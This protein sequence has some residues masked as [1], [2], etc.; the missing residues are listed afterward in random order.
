MLPNGAAALWARA[1]LRRRWRSLVVLG[2]LVGMTSALAMAALAGARRTSTA[3]GRLR[4]ATRAADAVVFPSQVNATHPDWRPLAAR[5]EVAR[6]AVWDLMFGNVNDSFGGLLFASDDGVFG[7]SVDRPVVVRG[8]MYDPAAPD[9]V[10]VDE[11]AARESP[12]GSTFRFQGY[13]LGTDD[14]SGLPPHGP[15]MTLRVVGVVR[16]VP[17]FLFVSDGQVLVSPGVVARYRSQMNLLENAD[18]VLRHG[19]ADIAALKRD[20]NALVAPGAPVLDL[21]AVSRRVDTTLAVER[22]ALVL[23]AAA[24]AL[25]GGILVAQ[26]LSRSASVVGD[27]VDALRAMGM[28]RADVGLASCLPHLATAAVAAVVALGGAVLASRWFPVGLGRR[29]DPNLGFHLDWTVIGPGVVATLGLV[30]GATLLMG[31]RADRRSAGRLVAPSQIAAWIRRTTPLTIGLGSAMAFERGRGKAAV[32]VRPALTAAAVGVLGIVATVAIDGGINDALAHPER[33]GVSWDADVTAN[34][35]DL[36]PAGTSPAVADRV[37][38]AAGPGASTA[39]VARGVTDVS[40]VGVPMFTVRPPRRSGAAPVAL[41]LKTGRAP[42]A[43]GEAAIGPATAADLHVGIGSTVKVGGAGVPVRIVGEALFPDDVHAEFDEGLWVTPATFDA[44]W[45]PAPDLYQGSVQSVIAVRLPPGQTAAGVSRLAKGLGSD[46]ADVSPRPSPVE[47]VNLRN[48]RVLPE[49][50]AGF[51]ALMAVAALGHVLLTSAR[52]RRRDFAILAA[53]GLGRGAVRRVLNAQGTA[54]GAVGLIVGVPL[55]L[56][57]G[58]VGWRLVTDRVPLL[59]VAPLPLR[60]TLVLLA[61]TVVMVNALAVWPGWLLTR[62][63]M[64]AEELRAE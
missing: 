1:D 25:A 8:R 32:A 41:A 7:G 15:R 33:A 47:L 22:T 19:R 51:L 52:R 44:V 46:V 63:H 35:A 43:T 57:L 64:P 24:V 14:R 50:L 42:R 12:L 11:N 45:P 60:E 18:V 16:T 13:E 31:V 3:L 53:M 55:G 39:E 27:D 20:M 61:A 9:E 28:T 26:A 38:V 49:L 58:R 30:T 56:A 10:V 59:Y 5:P 36:G 2:L 23:L 62:R 34:P 4:Q 48:V 54:L 37:A 6:I 29:I 21:H 17:Q 40:G